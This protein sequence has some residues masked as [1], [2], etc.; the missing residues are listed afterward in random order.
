MSQAEINKMLQKEI[1]R[2]K[3]LLEVQEV[4]SRDMHLHTANLH[5]ECWEK[6]FTHK[7]PDVS[8]EIASGGRVEGQEAVKNLY[9]DLLPRSVK[10]PVGFMFVHS[11][12]TP[13]IQIAGDGKTA[14]GVWFSPGHETINDNGKIQALWCWSYFGTDFIKEDGKWKMW[15]YHCYAMFKTPFEKSWVESSPEPVPPAE[16]ESFTFQN[17]PSTYYNPYTPTSIRELIPAPP[18]PYETFDPSKAY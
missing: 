12:D 11:L 13:S 5:K 6:L 10:N 2:L 15:H 14:K 7:A 4:M 17:K 3:D 8:A 9:C 1:Q 18:E 16:E